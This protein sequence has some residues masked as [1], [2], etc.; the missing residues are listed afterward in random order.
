MKGYICPIC[1]AKFTGPHFCCGKNTIQYVWDDP[2]EDACES[3]EHVIICDWWTVCTG[4]C[5]VC[6]QYDAK[7]Q[8]K[9][10]KIITWCE[11]N[12]AKK[13]IWVKE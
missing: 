12:C 1:N 7:M 2:Y 11:K 4:D 9:A 10:S 6:E 8:N 13:R 5:K 3:C